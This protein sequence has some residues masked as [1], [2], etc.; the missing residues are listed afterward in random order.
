MKRSLLFFSSLFLVACGKES[1][2]QQ[3]VEF[4]LH[5]VKGEVEDLKQD[6]SSYQIEI[7]MLEGKFLNL[8][9]DLTTLRDFYLKKAARYLET[10]P[11][12]EEKITELESRLS[13]FEKRLSQCEMVCR[14]ATKSTPQQTLL[15]PEGLPLQENPSHINPL[16][17]KTKEIGSEMSIYLV[18]KNDTLES[19]SAHLGVSKE[20]LKES[21]QLHNDLLLEGQELKI[22]PP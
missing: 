15:F 22:P 18:Q 7:G 9:D 19:I 1:V 16:K 8:D 21:N 2:D 13:Q 20:K 17:G 5:K 6:L 12:L 14:Q 3:Q 11:H 10:L 4:A